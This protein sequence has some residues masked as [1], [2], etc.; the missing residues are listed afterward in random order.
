MISSELKEIR[1]QN[2]NDAQKKVAEEEGEIQK[3][4]DDIEKANKDLKKI[5][6]D[7]PVLQKALKLEIKSNKGFF[8]GEKNP[9]IGKD[10]NAKKLAINKMDQSAIDLKKTIEE[11]K[12]KLALAEQLLPI[13]NKLEKLA[14]KQKR[15]WFWGGK[16]RKSRKSNKSTKKKR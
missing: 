13:T 1:V 7:L 11:L 16:S 3:L 15:N 14:V 5:N 12:K 10:I 8:Y 6:E 2:V 4:K 9:D